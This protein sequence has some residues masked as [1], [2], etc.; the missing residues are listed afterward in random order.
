MT[1][2]ERPAMASNEAE[3]AFLREAYR[4]A[5]GRHAANSFRRS[6]FMPVLIVAAF[7]VLVLVIV[8]PLALRQLGS[9]HGLNWVQLSNIGQTFGPLAVMHA[10]KSLVV[11]L[12]RGSIV[13]W[14][15]SIR[16]R[17]LRD[18]FRFRL[19]NLLLLRR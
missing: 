3:E 17:L 1:T 15:K 2:A 11:N 14:T 13:L 7:A 10:F 8:S 5:R 16:R 4:S 19:R 6:A 18:H 12:M 9:I